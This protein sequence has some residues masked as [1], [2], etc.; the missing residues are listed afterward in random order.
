MS[1]SELEDQLAELEEE[2]RR[3]A[4]EQEEGFKRPA[5]RQPEKPHEEDVLPDC[6]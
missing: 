6:M 3:E 2:A 1:Q 5:P 4:E